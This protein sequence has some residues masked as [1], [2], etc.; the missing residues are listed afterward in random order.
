MILSN[1]ARLG[2]ASRPRRIS[3]VKLAGTALVAHALVIV[4]APLPAVS[5]IRTC[6]DDVTTDA[7]A[8]SEH[9]GKRRALASWVSQVRDSAGV[10]YT[11]W[12][13]A[14]NRRLLCL[15]G[16]GEFRCVATGQACTIE[17]APT[18]AGEARERGLLVLPAPSPSLA[19]WPYGPRW[20]PRADHHHG[21]PR[22]SRH[23]Y[24][25]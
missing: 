1:P 17:H 12:E 8:A 21:G 13:L 11:R 6:I 25:H 4:M 20:Y 18:A 14:W 10:G 3:S 22:L 24:L 9:E 2:S 15:S 7:V 16:S 19:P 23:H 5:A